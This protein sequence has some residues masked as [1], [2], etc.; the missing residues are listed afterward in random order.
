MSHLNNMRGFFCDDKIV[1][2]EF[3]CS[4]CSEEMENNPVW[5]EFDG[6]MLTIQCSCHQAKTTI[7][8]PKKKRKNELR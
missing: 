1:K 2:T 3:L 6:K 5:I 7:I 4:I 8:L